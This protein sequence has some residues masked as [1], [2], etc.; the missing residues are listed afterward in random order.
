MVRDPLAVI[1]DA[2]AGA[3]TATEG[4]QAVAALAFEREL[5]FAGNALDLAP[6]A[7]PDFVARARK[8]FAPGRPRPIDPNDPTNE[9]DPQS[10]AEKVLRRQAPHLFR[11]GR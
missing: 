10:W 2:L 9:L 5:V 11:G 3:A 1:T 4:R 7:L 6:G 8:T